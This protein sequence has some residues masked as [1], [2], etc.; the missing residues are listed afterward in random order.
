[1][2]AEQ[3]QKLSRQELNKAYFES[4]L[5]KRV[6]RIID[7]NMPAVLERNKLLVKRGLYS[8]QGQRLIDTVPLDMR[9][10]SGSNVGG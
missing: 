5:H 1:M 6:K 8:P 4:P 2:L 7:S 10:D 9:A 3:E